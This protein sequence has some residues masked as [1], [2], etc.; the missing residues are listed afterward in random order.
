MHRGRILGFR[1]LSAG[2]GYDAR[3]IQKE[4]RQMLQLLLFWWCVGERY[5]LILSTAVMA[6]ATVPEMSERLVGSSSVVL[7]LARLPNSLT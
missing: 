3:G 7:S 6:A 2:R 5:F 4:L 1:Y